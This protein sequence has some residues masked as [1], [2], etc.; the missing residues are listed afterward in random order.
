MKAPKTKRPVFS[1][2]L[3]GI[4]SK[5]ATSEMPQAKVSTNMTTISFDGRQLAQLKRL[6]GVI[7]VHSC[8]EI[9]T[10]LGANEGNSRNVRRTASYA[11]YESH[12]LLSFNLRQYFDNPHWRRVAECIHTFAYICKVRRY[13]DEVV[14]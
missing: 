6:S 5:S 4:G 11:A 14:H 10:V 8:L 2:L 12:V 3:Y 1:K 13:Y 7:H 9:D